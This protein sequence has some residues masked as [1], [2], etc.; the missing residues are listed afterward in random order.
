MPSLL[1]ASGL[2]RRSRSVAS[3]SHEHTDS[4]ASSCRRSSSS[5]S[6]KASQS[7]SQL[8]DWSDG[9]TGIV[10]LDRR[11]RELA[12]SE[13]GRSPFGE[14]DA[15]LLYE[16]YSPPEQN[17][18]QSRRNS[19]ADTRQSNA[20]HSSLATGRSYP[21]PELNAPSCSS[22]TATS[23]FSH[24]SHTHS[25]L[26]SKRRSST[27]NTG[28]SSDC[29]LGPLRLAPLPAS[30]SVF[31]NYRLTNADTSPLPRSARPSSS[32]SSVEEADFLTPL[33]GATRQ[34]EPLTPG[35]A[36][37]ATWT[38]PT[39]PSYF[40]AGLSADSSSK[41][42]PRS[43]RRKAAR[44]PLPRLVSGE[45]VSS[46]VAEPAD[47]RFC[48]SPKETRL[49]NK[50][51]GSPRT[52]VTT[53]TVD[54]KD[55]AAAASQHSFRK[56]AQSLALSLRFKIIRA[57]RRVNRTGTGAADIFAPPHSSPGRTSLETSFPP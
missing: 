46:P 11:M 55:T 18:F 30:A 1:S 38:D 39:A 56:S 6:R 42:A 47:S 19:S 3:S 43:L 31:G 37:A 22:T 57:K 17:H 14:D 16:P 4:S 26:L 10:D 5:K 9:F 52:L 51:V 21:S 2:G 49:T 29:A 44:A 23:R 25:S 40:P 32:W 53:T 27:A 36:A 34:L 15:S 7:N 8:D 54:R 12:M 48:V 20:S 24:D 28:I 35:T 41:K 50:D 13:Q 33:A 45:V